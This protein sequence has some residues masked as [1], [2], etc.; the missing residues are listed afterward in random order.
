VHKFS[1]RRNITFALLK[2][3]PHV[4][5]WWDHFC[6][7]KATEEPSLFT[8]SPTQESFKDVI[9][10]EYYHVVSYDDMYTRWT[11]LRQERDWKQCH[12]SQ[13]S[14]IPCAPSCVSNIMINMFF[15]STSKVF[16]DT[17]RHKCNF[18]TSRRWARPIDILSRSSRSLN[19]RN[20][21]LG[22]G[23]PHSRRRSR[24][25]PTHKIKGIAKMDILRIASLNC[26]Q[27]RT[28]ERRR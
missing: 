9:K 21:S 1:N 7:E 26:K 5:Y 8:I 20:E 13:I 27:I 11:T 24:E 22:L 25:A 19:K 10:E 16:I 12:S 4:K 17:S 6:E 23:T 28:M 3:I 18:C 15:S 14:S 2:F